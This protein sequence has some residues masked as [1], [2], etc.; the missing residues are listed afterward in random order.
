MSSV[1]RYGRLWRL[2]SSTRVA[3]IAIAC[4]LSGAVACTDSPL[5]P[6]HELPS[7]TDA[8]TTLRWNLIARQLV[9]TESMTPP[10]AARAYANLS[11]AQYLAARAVFERRAELTETPDETRALLRAAIASASAEAI[12]YLFPSH[13]LIA[14]H[15]LAFQLDALGDS[16]ASAHAI[17]TGRA[18]GIEAASAAIERAAGDG[19]DAS[20]SGT[21]PSGPYFWSGSNPQE[22]HWGAVRP[23]LTTSGSALRAPP[24]PEPGSE[25]FLA[26]L[27]EV[28]TLAQ[29]RTQEQLDE[30]LYWADGPRTPT[31]AGH[32]NDLAAR[33]IDDHALSEEEA[34][35]VLARM[36]MAVMDAVIGCWDSKFT[37]W[38]IRPYQVDPEIRTPIGQP[39]HPSY[40]SGHACM[41][42]A[43]SAVLG[44]VFPTEA[45]RL[46]AMEQA[47]CDSRVYAGIHYRFDSEA[48]QRLGAAAAELAIA[49][50][51]P[52]LARSL[53]P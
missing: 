15:E 41:S 37:Y 19:A 4:A 17:E 38:L 7:T 44:T 25:A 39:P 48:G 26:A 5:A 18:I 6:G 35:A 1:L 45:T 49:A 29:N 52:T 42:G 50:Y 47:A 22:P 8:G 3:T 51:L 40:P 9:T 33:L 16:L 53:V 11:V 36:N 20:W 28:H 14:A 21:A 27:E 34:V 31:P 2:P 30:V 32:W 43:A 23:W 24:P 10:R 13:A 12:S 46:A